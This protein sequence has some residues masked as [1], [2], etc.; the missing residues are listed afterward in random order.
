MHR[1]EYLVESSTIAI[2]DIARQCDEAGEQGWEL[3]SALV[4]QETS[5][6][7]RTRLIFKRAKPQR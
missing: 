1:W 2:S 7:A 5:G 3:V 6:L 4:V